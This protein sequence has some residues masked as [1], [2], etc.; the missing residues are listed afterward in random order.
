MVG[1]NKTKSAPNIFAY[2]CAQGLSGGIAKSEQRVPQVCFK[3]MTRVRKPT[4]S[5]GDCAARL[6]FMLEVDPHWHDAVHGFID[7]GDFPIPLQNRV[8]A[9]ETQPRWKGKGRVDT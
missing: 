9:G 2:M 5:K 8:R 6:Q 3:F 4:Q 1:F 7:Q